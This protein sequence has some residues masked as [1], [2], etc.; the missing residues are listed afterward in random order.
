MPNE[1]K[2]VIPAKEKALLVTVD[3]SRSY[4]QGR[5]KYDKTKS[6]WS[7]QDCAAELKELANSS[8]INIASEIICRREKPTPNYFIGKGK[9][10][11][12]AKVCQDITA[13]VVIC[14]ENLSSTQQRNLEDLISVKVIDRT[15]LILDIFAQRA[16]SQEGKVQVELAQLEYLLPRLIGKG[17]LLSR[18]GGGIG[19]RGPGEQKLEVDRR[20]IRKRIF[21]LKKE[22]ESLKERRYAKR[23]E[24]ESAAVTTIA[25]IGYTNAGKSTLLNSL[26]GA[27]VTVR[28]E[29]FSTLDPTTRKFIL[30]NNQKV[31]FVDTVGFLHDLPHYLIESFKATL[32]EVIEADLLVHVLDASHTKAP[33]QLQAVYG[34]L[35]ELNAQ[36]KPIITALNKIDKLENEFVLNRFLKTYDNCVAISALRHQNLDKLI[37]LIMQ[38]V[39]A[40]M[41][42]IN[43]TIPHSQMRLV[44]IIHNEG[45]VIK[46]EY[47]PDGIYIEAQVPIKLKQKLES[48]EKI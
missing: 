6:N 3:L 19:T 26:T 25:I 28:D 8:G 17:V 47:K 43:L 30:P 16:K 44:N 22:L 12:I 48:H 24:R 23:K 15:Q 14:N 45:K 1:L 32:E 34:V 7:A 33:E 37:S 18:L 27:E 46:E 11:E 2:E 31:L 35:S 41:S 10:L 21:K 20:R 9:A 4:T 5:D 42:K 39:S 13:D 36:T 40:L 38:K 29:L